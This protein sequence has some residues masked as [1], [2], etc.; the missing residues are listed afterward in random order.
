MIGTEESFLHTS[1][2]SS[3]TKH[4]KLHFSSKLL[5]QSFPHTLTVLFL[6]YHRPCLPTIF[7]KTDHCKATGYVSAHQP[8][9]VWL[10]GSIH[11]TTSTS[12]LWL[13]ILKHLVNILTPIL[14]AR[15]EKQGN[16]FVMYRLVYLYCDFYRTLLDTLLSLQPQRAVTQGESREDKVMRV[17]NLSHM[18]LFPSFFT[19]QVLNLAADVLKR[20]PEVIDYEATLKNIADDMSPLNVVLLQEVSKLKTPCTILMQYFF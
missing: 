11:R 20:V 9:C 3:M 16:F 18:F 15:S 5:S 6:G 14:P 8:M 7:Q 19:L 2:I 4:L 17:C 13:I 1:M 10:D 12:C